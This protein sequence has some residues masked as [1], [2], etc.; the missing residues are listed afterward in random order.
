[1]SD[2]NSDDPLSSR[3]ID[4]LIERHTG[5]TARQFPDEHKDLRRLVYGV[6]AAGIQYAE[7]PFALVPGYHLE[8]DQLA[9]AC[10]NGSEYQFSDGDLYGR[11]GETLAGF[12]AEFLTQHQLEQKLISTHLRTTPASAEQPEKE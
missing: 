5:I 2:A 10:F 1:M 6:L 9:L 8:N 12:T 11:E 3:G 4:I 7:Q